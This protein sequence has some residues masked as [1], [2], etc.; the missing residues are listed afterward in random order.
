MITSLTAESDKF[1]TAIKSLR[2]DPTYDPGL[3]EWEKRKRTPEQELIEEVSRREEW[4][5][6]KWLVVVGIM[7]FFALNMQVWLK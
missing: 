6:A 3:V 5:W 4:A 1:A 2:G 7:T